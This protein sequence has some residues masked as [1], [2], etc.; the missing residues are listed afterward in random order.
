M[1]PYVYFSMIFFSFFKILFIS[2]RERDRAQVGREAGRATGRS[3]FHHWAGSQIQ[4]SIPGFWDHDLSRRLSLNRLD[5]PGTFAALLTTVKLW[6]QHKCPSSTDECIKKRWYIYTMEYYSVIKKEWN[7]A[8]EL[9]S[10]MPSE[11]SQ[12]KKKKYHMISL[13]CGI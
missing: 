10:I 9:E 12:T 3:R 5:H 4:N 13:I 2:Q 8:M 6:K 1:H 7:L 11:I